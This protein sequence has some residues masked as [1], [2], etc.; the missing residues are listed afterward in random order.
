MCVFRY[1]LGLSGMKPSSPAKRAVLLSKPQE[2]CSVCVF[3]GKLQQ[4]Y[5]PSIS[6]L[7]CAEAYSSRCLGQNVSNL[8]PSLSLSPSLPSVLA[9]FHNIYSFSPFMLFISPCAT[10]HYFTPSLSS[11][12][13]HFLPLLPST[14]HFSVFIQKQ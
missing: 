8:P 2:K 3:V 9:F 14:S 11:S 4:C 6:R 10:L 12:I 5:L 7:G 1:G 13:S